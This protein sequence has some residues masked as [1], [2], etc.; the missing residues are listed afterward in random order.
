MDLIRPL[1][2]EV[3]K[4]IPGKLTN[5]IA[6]ARFM[7]KLSLPFANRIWTRLEMDEVA[8]D[9]QPVDLTDVA[10]VAARKKKIESREEE[11][12][13]FEDVV[14]VARELSK[15]S[16]DRN[17]YDSGIATEANSGRRTIK[18]EP[19]SGR[20]KK[21]LEVME[22]LKQWTAVMT[23]R[24]AATEKKMDQFMKTAAVAQPESRPYTQQPP[25]R[26][27]EFNRQMAP[28][29]M[30]CHYCRYNGHF[31]QNCEHRR[32]HIEEGKLHV[33][34]GRDLLGDGTNLFVPRGDGKS[35]KEFVEDHYRKM[36]AQN[37]FSTAAG[38][39]SVTTD[40]EDA[41]FSNGVDYDPRDDEIRSLRIA[42]QKLQ[43][44]L[45]QVNQGDRTTQLVQH[46]Q[47][48]T[49]VVQPTPVASTQTGGDLEKVISMMSTIA[50]QMSLT[51]QQLLAQTRSSANKNGTNPPSN[52]GF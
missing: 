33:M 35:K 44:Q 8:Y 34:N 36:A 16:A 18:V 4:L 19:D 30:L 51:Q 26:A 47:I 9:S 49:G 24:F 28:T 42:E 15:G 41:M 27:P 10:A 11:R 40:I 29:E 7:D 48:P 32:K 31:I 37:Y 23:D 21:Q 14:R 25:Q 46:A 1:Q 17:E 6:I 5:K 13:Q 45:A 52:E 12:Y 22:D 3:E 43:R 38:V 50:Q 20:D 39:Y 2:V